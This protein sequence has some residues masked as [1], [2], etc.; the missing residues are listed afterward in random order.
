MDTRCVDDVHDRVTA[1]I[2]LWIDQPLLKS[3]CTRQWRNLL[4]AL[5]GLDLML[6]GP[7]LRLWFD[8]IATEAVD[9]ALGPVEHATR[10]AQGAMLTG[11]EADALVRDGVL[12][13]GP[14]TAPR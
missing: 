3:A 14:A 13:E 5:R 7:E 9:A 11:A 12:D 10:R 6:V 1:Q 8:V 2:A 4:Q